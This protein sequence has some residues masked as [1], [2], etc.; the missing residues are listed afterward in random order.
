[1]AVI[2]LVHRLMGRNAPVVGELLV[3]HTGVCL[4]DATLATSGTEWLF[5]RAVYEE[6]IQ[7]E[8][9]GVRINSESCL[10]TKVHR[11]AT[12]TDSAGS[13]GDSEC[14]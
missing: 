10:I 5:L 6:R 8:Y 12:R 4:M 1:M 9:S 13:I 14:E 11:I 7:T 3:P 2:G